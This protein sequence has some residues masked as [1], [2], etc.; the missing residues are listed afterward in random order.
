MLRSG[1]CQG[2]TAAPEGARWTSLLQDTRRHLSPRFPDEAHFGAKS[3]RWSG[4]VRHGLRDADLI[5]G[6]EACAKERQRRG[7]HA[8]R[9]GN[10]SVIL[11]KNEP[12]GLLC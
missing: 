11:C 4:V 1:T 2:Q 12:L 6:R 9:N 8:K 5:V 7:Y 10:Q 3:V